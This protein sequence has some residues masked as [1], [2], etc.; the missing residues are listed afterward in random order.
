VSGS[1]GEAAC[2]SRG[3]EREGKVGEGLLN[4]G[5][6]RLLLDEGGGCVLQKIGEVGWV[7]WHR[8]GGREPGVGGPVGTDRGLLAPG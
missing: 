1:E 6:R 8:D 2:V 7:R 5:L 3:T 4:G